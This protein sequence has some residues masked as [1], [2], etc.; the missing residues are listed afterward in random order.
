MT[1]H[2]KIL[3]FILAQ[4][5]IALDLW[6]FQGPHKVQERGGRGEVGSALTADRE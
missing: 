1:Q 4:V 3:I 2:S 6:Q 5:A